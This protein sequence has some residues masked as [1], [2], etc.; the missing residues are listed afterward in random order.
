M[1][2]SIKIGVKKEPVKK[3]KSF[4]QKG[5]GFSSNI[6]EIVII[7][8]KNLYKDINIYDNIRISLT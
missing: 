5:S 6:V 7:T 3:K 4:S 8:A 2:R 1:K